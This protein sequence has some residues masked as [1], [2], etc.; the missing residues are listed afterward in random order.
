MTVKLLA[1]DPFDCGCTEC[2]TGEY[3]PLRYA[4]A[5]Q[6]LAMMTGHLRDHTYGGLDL[7]IKY[8]VEQGEHPEYKAKL[9]ADGATI[10]YEPANQTW[11]VEA[12]ELELAGILPTC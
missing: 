2:L 5:V 1:I 8:T 9:V 10:T 6:I 12:W 3:V 4:T 7:R 11:E